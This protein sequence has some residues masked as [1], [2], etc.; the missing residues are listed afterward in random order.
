MAIRL[1][2]PGARTTK[3]LK[4]QGGQVN[5]YVF[6]PLSFFALLDVSFSVEIWVCTDPSA[7]A[8]MQPILTTRDAAAGTGLRIGI[9]NQLISLTIAGRTFTGV[10][11]IQPGV[12][13]HLAW[14]Y[15]VP[16]EP[17][18][19][20]SIRFFVNG[21]L[22]GEAAVPRL[23]LALLPS[24][25]LQFA[26][27]APTQT[28]FS[29]ELSELRITA[30]QPAIPSQRADA[31]TRR[32]TAPLP[33][34]YHRL[35]EPGSSLS[36]RIDLS[37][38]AS[39][40]LALAEYTP[41]QVERGFLNGTGYSTLNTLLPTQNC[42]YSLFVRTLST[43]ATLLSILDR[44]GTVLLDLSI[45]SGRPTVRIA[46]TPVVP[47]NTSVSDGRWHHLAV[48]IGPSRVT[49]SV[50]GSLYV[51]A[52]VTTLP[53]QIGASLEL[54]RSRA[55][56]D[57]FI[58]FI[59]EVQVWN[60][61]RGINTI[62][63]ELRAVYGPTNLPPLLVGYCR[64]FA[65]YRRLIDYRRL[66][67]GA[68]A[69]GTVQK[70]SPGSPTNPAAGL[71]LIGGGSRVVFPA[72]GLDLLP[73]ATEFTIEFYV[74]Y[75]NPNVAPF[76][77]R[78]S[79]LYEDGGSVLE[80]FCQPILCLQDQAAS[81][82]L[83]RNL[84]DSQWHHIALTCKIQ[85]TSNQCVVY[86]DGNPSSP[87]G[88]TWRRTGPR[89]RSTFTFSLLNAP[90]TGVSVDVA[91][92]R[93]WSIA[94]A[95]E[96]L[97]KTFVSLMSVPPG[98]VAMW[99]T[100]ETGPGPL[101]HYGE[102][103]SETGEQVLRSVPDPIT[104]GQALSF[105]GTGAFVRIQN[106]SALAIPLGVD[107][108]LALSLQLAE[109][110]QAGATEV[111]LLEKRAAS[112]D[113]RHFSLRYLTATGALQFSRGGVVL[114]SQAA[115]K[116][117]SWHSVRI[118]GTS[119]EYVLTIDNVVQARAPISGTLFP[120]DRIAEIYLGAAA[121]L[122][123]STSGTLPFRGAVRGLELSVQGQLLA[124]WRLDSLSPNN[125]SLALASV[126]LI[127][128]PVTV[129]DE[130]AL[131]L[132]D[133]ARGPAL[134]PM[135]DFDGTGSCV[136]VQVPASAPAV[137]ALTVEAW[138]RFPSTTL[139]LTPDWL[140][141]D[142]PGPILSAGGAERGWELRCSDYT[143]SFAV[144]DVG[145]WEVALP[146]QV[147]EDTLFHIAVVYSVAVAG[148]PQP[149]PQIYLNGVL[150]RS[151]HELCAHP[152]TMPLSGGAAL[153]VT[154]LLLGADATSQTRF[155]HGQL[156]EVRGFSRARTPGEIARDLFTRLN[157]SEEG[158][159]L[160][161]PLTDGEG[162]VAAA[163]GSLPP[164][165]LRGATWLALDAENRLPR[166][167]SP[168]LQLTPQLLGQQRNAAIFAE[169]T[170]LVA[171]IEALRTRSALLEQ[172]LVAQGAALKARLAQLD[173]EAAP[174]RLALEQQ[175]AA[176][177]DRAARL[178]AAGVDAFLEDLVLD[179][180]DQ[181][182][183]GRSDSTAGHRLEKV[184]LDLRFSAGA[185]GAGANFPPPSSD[186]DA[187]LLSTLTVELDPRAP[188]PP[189]ASEIEVPD[190]RGYTS[191][192]ARSFLRGVGLLTDLH[193]QIVAQPDQI[194][195]VLTQY[196]PNG[197]RAPRGSTVLLF[198]GKA[199]NPG[200]R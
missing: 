133:L 53:S 190:V 150:Q 51:P 140:D 166:I 178:Q 161:L 72:N 73:N 192:L 195:R 120:D 90:T 160:Y 164:G 189:P 148:K 20:A 191:A 175:V 61:E 122:F 37:A 104:T 26:Y 28:A 4:L 114:T 197:T 67:L 155:F 97:P 126:G 82:P 193:E 98:V 10:T 170:Q 43:N 154:P 165:N 6:G 35:D 101:A 94:L 33:L 144:W 137:T 12:F 145:T 167:D 14:W 3:V 103:L 58:G 21:I 8:A 69:Q 2:Q 99:P 66:A 91:E 117:T 194:A 153:P 132:Q 168:A 173:A 40:A 84:A 48:A 52:T 156:A 46:G 172:D 100:F 188:P 85:S 96:Q 159:F 31:I 198:V 187:A 149:P 121:P 176:L 109:T 127:D 179:V 1:S 77:C 163:P 56:L 86:V 143:I 180:R 106:G 95:P 45:L 158:L 128:N 162:A 169:Y 174:A 196:P 88:A 134:I 60:N 87:A 130:P 118:S 110:Q 49:L 184:S 39:K 41:T 199:T 63:S 55:P 146:R 107:F 75:I 200:L 124:T 50:D 115:Y 135:L 25:Q 79:L 80:L 36:A 183:S 29:G 32:A 142:Q 93:L 62:A 57:P 83:G 68:V 182:D 64:Y 65:P 111:V 13:Y 116:D 59:D 5:R 7:G 136:E 15:M 125:T 138:V 9:E 141:G 24:R 177:K 71:R 171:D 113:H 44:A 119:T 23:T 102:R 18:Q 27:Y 89:Q 11:P 151:L 30:P 108:A 123:G 185:G 181:L 76:P 129:V 186:I 70:P 112:S 38:V 105:D 17:N 152:S 81:V 147:P 139:G 131:P 19:D 157:G 92:F 78:W 54:G 74:R 22:D 34:L 42:T 47:I 16:D